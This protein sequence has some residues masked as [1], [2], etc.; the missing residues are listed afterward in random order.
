MRVG[1]LAADRRQRNGGQ[2]EDR[3]RQ[4]DFRAGVFR[5]E[6]E[7]DQHRQHLANEIV[8]EGGEELAPEQRR[9]TPRRISWL[10]MGRR[11]IP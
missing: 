6:A 1:D 3:D 4:R 10:N 9:E 2:H 5:A 11:Y 8:V 7:Q